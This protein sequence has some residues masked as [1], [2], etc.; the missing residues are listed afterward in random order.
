MPM[1]FYAYNYNYMFCTKFAHILEKG[2]VLLENNSRN[3]VNFKRFSI[4]IG[5]IKSINWYMA[6]CSYKVA[7]MSTQL[8]QT[9]KTMTLFEEHQNGE[10]II[11]ASS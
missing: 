3:K 11:Y 1:A 9:Q 7:I 10:T 2:V 8:R 5:K 4:T 6:R